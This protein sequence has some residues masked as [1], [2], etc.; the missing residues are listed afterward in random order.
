[1]KTEDGYFDT[2][3]YNGPGGG[4]RIMVRKQW[5]DDSDSLHRLP[6]TFTVYSRADRSVVGTVTLQDGVWYTSVGIGTLTPEE[7]YVLETRWAA[8]RCPIP[9]EAKGPP[10][11]IITARRT[12]YAYTA[13]QYETD[14]HRYEVVYTC[15]E[16]AARPFIPRSTGGWAIS[17]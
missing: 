8:T 13:V 4:N 6:V 7:V 17:T 14:Y 2:T 15:E 1:M 16:I 5:I 10:R 9:G 11:R 12:P 3:V